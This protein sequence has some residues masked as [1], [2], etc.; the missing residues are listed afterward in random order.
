MSTVTTR[1]PAR[2]MLALIALATDLPLPEHVRTSADEWYG[3]THYGLTLG[4]DTIAEGSAWAQHLGATVKPY[5]SDGK[6]FLGSKGITVWHGW[7][8]TLHAA[9]PVVDEAESKAELAGVDQAA[10]TELAGA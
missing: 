9:E 1:K 7:E 10:L 6:R 8:V 4:F 3:E 2:A 5:V